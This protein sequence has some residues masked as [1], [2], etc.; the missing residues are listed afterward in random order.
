MSETLQFHW[1]LPT[2]GDGR[3]LGGSVH[4]VGIGAAGGVSS[5]IG[6]MRV[7]GQREASLDYLTQI[8]RAA[9]Q[10]GYQGVLTPTGAHCED[11]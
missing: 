5:S 9:D 6:S 10:L 11:A 4:G 2:E 3:R 1:F 8:A 7:E